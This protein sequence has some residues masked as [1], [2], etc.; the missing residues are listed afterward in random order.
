MTK[1]SESRYGTYGQ[2][3]NNTVQRQI[4]NHHHPS[5]MMGLWQECRLFHY[6][7]HQA[8]KT[9]F[10]TSRGWHHAVICD[11]PYRQFMLAP[12]PSPFSICQIRCPYH[13]AQSCRD[14]KSCV[15]TGPTKTN[16]PNRPTT[17][18]RS[19]NPNRPNTPNRPTTPQIHKHHKRTITPSPKKQ[20]RPP[21]Q[22]PSIHHQR[23]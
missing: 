1:I 3:K 21:I 10:R 2:R 13:H 22:K 5:T 16:N 11:R 8:S 20:I 17:Q 15:S 7:L 4:Q 9:S 23:I 6:H 14:A 18:N 19:T 12:D